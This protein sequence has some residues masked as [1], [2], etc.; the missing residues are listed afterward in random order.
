[1]VKIKSINGYVHVIL[2]PQETKEVE[3]RSK[4]PAAFFKNKEKRA[5]QTWSSAGVRDA[6]EPARIKERTPV[7]RNCLGR[8]QER[9]SLPDD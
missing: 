2:S 6:D 4:G 5:P 1:M 7:L 9:P 3:V 8:A